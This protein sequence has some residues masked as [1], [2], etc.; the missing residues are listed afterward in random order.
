M[1]KINRCGQATVLSR[2]EIARLF[3]VISSQNHRLIFA[4]CRYTTERITAVLKLE[5]LDV[6]DTRGKVRPIITFRGVNRK[7][8][9]GKPGKTRQ[10]PVHPR[11]KEL[12]DEYEIPQ[13]GK[14]LFPSP[15]DSTRHITRQSVD[16]ALR[17]A[18]EKAGLGDAGVSTHSFRRTAITELANSGVSIRVIQEV[19]GHASLTQLKAYI[20]VSEDQV[21]EAI[22]LL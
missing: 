15:N 9:K 11:L 6:Y 14:W 2:Q 20:E 22:K 18:C 17:R 3:R 4:I 7:G 5:P 1:P 10:V 21:K 8:S 19:T 16:E 13:G 12:L